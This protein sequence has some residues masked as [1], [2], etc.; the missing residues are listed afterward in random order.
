MTGDIM[1]KTV[2]EI[3]ADNFR[4]AEVFKKYNVDFCCGGKKAVTVVCNEKG[5][6]FSKLSADLEECNVESKSSNLDYNEWTLT[7]LTNYIVQVHHAYVNRNM[8]LITEFAEKVASV[9]GLHNPETVKISELWTKVCNELTSHMRKEEMVLFPYIQKMELN[10]GCEC[11]DDCTCGDNC[12]CGKVEAPAFGTI[13]NPINMME[14]EHD[15]AGNLM[16]E[17]RKLTENYVAPEYA[18]NT[19]K[20]LYAKL[21]EFENDLHVHIHLENNILFPKAIVLEERQLKSV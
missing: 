21:Q 1:T 17:I 20:V 15:V 9:H 3:V 5:I 4:T 7:F 11:G 12:Q 2:A 6:D 10:K 13:K 14:H 16:K 19:Y 8:P 18:C